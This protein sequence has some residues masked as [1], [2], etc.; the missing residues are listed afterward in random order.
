MRRNK[1]LIQFRTAVCVVVE[2]AGSQLQIVQ[3][4]A[5]TRWMVELRPY[6]R[7]NREVADLIFEDGSIAREVSFGFF[8]FL[9]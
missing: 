1:W 5:G 6:H 3:V 7:D 9:E 2:G 4:R 8:Q